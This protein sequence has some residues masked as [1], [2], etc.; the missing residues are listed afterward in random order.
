MIPKNKK[1]PAGYEFVNFAGQPASESIQS[2]IPGRVTIPLRQGFGNEV[3]AVVEVGQKVSAGEIIGRDDES[4][5]SPVHSSVNG[6]VVEIEKI[7]YLGNET[8]AIVIESDGTDERQSLKGHSLNWE[9]LSAE[10]ISELIYLSGVSSSGSGGIP[11]S[12][13]SSV[14]GPEEVED[15]IVQGVCSE[16]HNPC[17]G[18]LLGGEGFSRFVAGLEILKKLMPRARFHLALDEDQ[19]SLFREVS[20]HLPN[21]DFVDVVRLP[22]KYPVDRDE[23]LTSLVLGKE[24]PW[25]Y[26]AANIGV[27]VLDIQSVLHV[28]EAVVE[29]KALIERAIAL[30]GPGFIKPI[31]VH[32]RIGSSLEDVVKGKVDSE[33]ELRFVTD[34][35]IAGESFSDLSLPINRSTKSIISLIEAREREFLAF[36]LPGFKK[37]A[38]ART[39]FSR[40]FKKGSTLFQKTC[41]TNVKGE[42]RPCIFCGFC[43]SVCPVGIIPH[44][45]FH[46][47]E[48]E[49]IDESLLTFKIFKCIECNLCNYVCPSKIHIA[50]F[51]SE[52]KVKLAEEGF[53]LPEPGVSLKGV[54]KYKSLE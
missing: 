54:E 40:I 19:K 45:L 36:A 38:Y 32:A 52:G 8:T 29:G 26:L 22:S 23:I 13:N 18:Y 2:G 3:S 10:T 7:E 16:S 1:F 37:D 51:I 53:E 33:K 47:V 42:H 5:S 17:L 14:I 25:G 30:C 49:I 11:T 46:Y 24:F 41:G 34:S 21:G 28:Y 31:H 27:I 39:S 50:Q 48:R 35:V 15:V 44:H 20:E 4:V 6:T 9:V 12:F 43:E